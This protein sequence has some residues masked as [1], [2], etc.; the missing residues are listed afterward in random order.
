[1]HDEIRNFISDFEDAVLAS[2][3]AGQTSR[4]AKSARRIA[5]NLVR[6]LS[7]DAENSPE[8]SDLARR[9]EGLETKLL[10]LSDA[11][12]DLGPYITKAEAMLALQGIIPEDAIETVQQLLARASG[13]SGG[14]PRRRR[15]NYDLGVECLEC[16]AVVAGKKGGS[17]N[18]G[19]IR[20]LITRHDAA[21][22]DGLSAQDRLD[23]RSAATQLEDGA[24]EVSVTRYRIYKVGGS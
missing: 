18:W 3:R 19:L 5:R 17:P 10:E 2:E 1:M 21:A 16:D 24:P 6:V 9:A 22:H 13:R 20:T 7:E 15:L 11:K 12:K 8:L 14:G 4:R 23:L